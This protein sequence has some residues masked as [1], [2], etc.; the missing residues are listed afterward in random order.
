MPSSLPMYFFHVN[1]GIALFYAFYRLLC[2]RDTFFITRRAVLILSLLGAFLLPLPEL[3]ERFGRDGSLSF[4]TDYYRSVILPELGVTASGGSF[5]D[6]SSFAAVSN[7][8]LH[9]YVLGA[10]LFL[11]RILIQ[12]VSLLVLGMKSEPG[13]L[14][15]VKVRLIPGDAGPFS[16]FGWIFISRKSLF[17]QGLEDV[18]VHEQTHVRQYHSMDVLLT[19]TVNALLWVNPFSWLLKREVR[20]NLEYLA[21]RK[22]LESGIERKSYQYHLLGLSYR[23]DNALTNSF[24]VVSL[25][26]R[27]VMM[28][29]RRTG[30]VGYV[31]YTLLTFPV[32]FLLIAGNVACTSALTEQD[33]QVETVVLTG[34]KV[35]EEES[36]TVED[37]VFEE[38]ELMPEFPGGIKKLLNF[39]N[40]NIVYPQAAIDA[41]IQGRVVV[42]FIV[43]KDGTPGNFEIMRPVSPELD[44]EV[45]RVLRLMPEWKPAM[46]NGQ[47]VRCK[48]TVPVTFRLQ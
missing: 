30:I 45:L 15:G 37:E 9:I 27:I 8:L 34:A 18:L 2:T 46:K 3:A 12:L 19:E 43:E 44:V 36:V 42:Q 38:A 24:N 35:K 32:L 4:A 29:R 7:I 21:D 22:V 16:F 31:K 23:Q 6:G 28:N 10:G 48:L 17:G 14:H 41:E 47:A 25:K 39:L 13:E 5:S 40:K 20:E 33:S 26:R 11:L 1:L